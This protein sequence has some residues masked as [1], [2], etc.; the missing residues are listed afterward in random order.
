MGAN[1]V[2]EPLVETE[3]K[4]YAERTPYQPLLVQG[5][6]AGYSLALLLGRLS[7]LGPLLDIAPACAPDLN[8]P[9]FAITDLGHEA[10]GTMLT[11]ANPHDE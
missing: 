1:S 4:N 10:L 2:A 8:D 6:H 5:S 11:R 9:I 7:D 3:N